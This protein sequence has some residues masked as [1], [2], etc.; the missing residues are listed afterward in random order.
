ME[1][2]AKKQ[3]Y[4]FGDTILS[5]KTAILYYH[6][7]R[8]WQK[9]QYKLVGDFDKQTGKYKI[10]DDMLNE[11]VATKKSVEKTQG[12]KKFLFAKCGKYVLRFVLKIGQVDPKT[13]YASLKFLEEYA[14]VEGGEKTQIATPVAY[15]KDV[16][17]IYFEQKVNKVFNIQ[18]KSESDD[19]KQMDN[20]EI[21]K[22]IF[23]SMSLSEKLFSSILRLSKQKNKLYVTGMLKIFENSGK[24]GK[25]AL[26]RYKALYDQYAK[27]LDPKSEKYWLVLKQIVDQIMLEEEKGLS[28]E[29]S[30][31]ISKLRSKYLP[32]IDMVIDK[33]KNP[34]KK[35]EEKPIKLKGS[36]GL[37]FKGEAYK[38]D[39]VK[40][41][42]S[43]KSGTFFWQENSEQSSLS[44]KSSW[45]EN[46]NQNLENQ[47]SENAIWGNSISQWREETEKVLDAIEQPIPQ[48]DLK[49]EKQQSMAKKFVDKQKENQAME[50]F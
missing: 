21:A 16:D 42:A 1:E 32:S 23:E 37:F 20:S 47:T 41:A 13:K 14:F 18:N 30:S 3:E 26:R 4:I 45:K 5:D 6:Q 31:T 34:P 28:K 10:S 27:N 49:S 46:S 11:L 33:A 12:D 7:A 29:L 38:S 36:G 24:F 8:M 15:Y 48:K 35:V 2:Q 25:F 17:D 19:G 9:Y 39:G 40:K 44:R 43:K 50:M 22:K